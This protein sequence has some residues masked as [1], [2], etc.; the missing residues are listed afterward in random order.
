VT[1]LIRRRLCAAMPRVT[2]LY[3]FPVKSMGGIAADKLYIGATGA[4]TCSKRPLRE[5]LDTC[6]HLF[7]LLLRSTFDSGPPLHIRRSSLGP[8]LAGHARGRALPDAATA[9]KVRGVP[10]ATSCCERLE[11]EDCTP[12][13]F[14]LPCT[15]AESRNK[16]GHM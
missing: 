16:V 12:S 8:H 6:P 15:Q 14:A 3:V 7:I 13:T 2:G 4:N 9:P 11:T 5:V 1:A 10:G